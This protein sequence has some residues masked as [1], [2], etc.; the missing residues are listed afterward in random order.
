MSETQSDLERLTAEGW[1]HVGIYPG[2]RKGIYDLRGR[3]HSMGW[4]EADLTALGVKWEPTQSLTLAAATR[5]GKA[6]EDAMV[7]RK[8]GAAT[9]KRRA[10]RSQG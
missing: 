8:E 5:L 7:N 4:S 3:S 6:I 10:K 1:R 2:T 9:D